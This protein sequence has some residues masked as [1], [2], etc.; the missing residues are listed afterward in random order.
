MYPPHLFLTSL[1][2][3]RAQK[4]SCLAVSSDEGG[5]RGKAQR[6]KAQHEAGAACGSSAQH[7]SRSE[8]SRLTVSARAGCSTTISVNVIRLN[9]QLYP[10]S[11]PKMALSIET[12]RRM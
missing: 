6:K 12:W 4:P 5:G 1:D 9:I 7:A 3:D 11:F 2:S 10:K 8:Q